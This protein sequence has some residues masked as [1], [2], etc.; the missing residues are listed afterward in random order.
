MTK[1]DCMVIGD[2]LNDFAAAK[3]AGIECMAF[4]GATG[5][6]TPEYKQKCI[7]AGVYSVAATMNELHQKLSSWAK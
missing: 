5:N 1:K 6:N 3:S 4:V 2:S 7:E